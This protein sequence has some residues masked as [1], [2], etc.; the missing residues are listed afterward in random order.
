MNAQPMSSAS[1]A[2]VAMGVYYNY[3]GGLPLCDLSPE[4]SA[5]TFEEMNASAAGYYER[6]V[7]QESRNICIESDQVS[8]LLPC[9]QE[10]YKPEKHVVAQHVDLQGL[11]KS[12]SCPVCGQ[13]LPNA[14]A[15]KR[16]I[17]PY[18]PPELY[19]CSEPEVCKKSAFTRRDRLINHYRE[20][21]SKNGPHK[22]SADDIDRIRATAQPVYKGT[23]P[24]CCP[25]CGLIMPNVSWTDFWEVRIRRYIEM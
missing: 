14:I 6:N 25:L 9:V 20:S 11:T 13:E 23:R 10:M 24:R 15:L 16:H 5:D 3:A 7:P 22:V 4:R 1:P 17:A 18:D 12:T 8:G 19:Q 21:S 2:D